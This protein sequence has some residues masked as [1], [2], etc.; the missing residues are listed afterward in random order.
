[1]NDIIFFI[2]YV[3]SLDTDNSNLKLY[4]YPYPYEHSDID[5]KFSDTMRIGYYA[6]HFILR[7]SHA[8]FFF[9][10]NSCWASPWF[11]IGLIWA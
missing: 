2:I 6:D 8:L 5:I 10:F 1:M 11:L 9:F 7:C 3:C 4:P